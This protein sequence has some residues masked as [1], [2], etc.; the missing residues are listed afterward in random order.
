MFVLG[1]LNRYVL[2]LFKFTI[3]VTRSLETIIFSH[4]YG[5]LYVVMCRLLCFTHVIYFLFVMVALWN[6]ADHY[7]F[8]LWLL[9]L[10]FL[11]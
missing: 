8:A 9:L 5:R 7:I 1:D 3:L 10:F 6:R 11:A 4:Y 2:G